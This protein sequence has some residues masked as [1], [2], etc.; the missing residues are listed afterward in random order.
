MK[1]RTFLEEYA[2]HTALNF[3][4]VM[5]GVRYIYSHPDFDAVAARG[6]LKHFWLSFCFRTKRIANDLYF[7]VTP[8]HWHHAPGE[9]RGMLAVPFKKWFFYGYS[10]WQFNEDGE[11]R[12][13][14]NGTEDRRWDPRC[15]TPQ[16]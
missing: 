10:A 7:T 5:Q 8:P 15:K 14:L 6:S 1:F 11:V 16:T 4:Q 9:L 2:K 12:T 3:G 13:D